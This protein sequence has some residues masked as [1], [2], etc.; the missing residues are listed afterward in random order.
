VDII[1]NI[2]IA[3]SEQ[4]TPVEPAPSPKFTVPTSDLIDMQGTASELFAWQLHGVVHK[5]TQVKTACT[6]NRDALNA[7]VNSTLL[8]PTKFG[9]TFCN[10][11]FFSTLPTP[12]RISQQITEKLT[13]L[14]TTNLWN[15][16]DSDDYRMLI[17]GAWDEGTPTIDNISSQGVMSVGM[18]YQQFFTEMQDRCRSILDEPQP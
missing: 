18:D 7:A 17:C 9:A 4:S 15:F 12:T 10:K 8:D 16:S 6:D 13:H 5:P 1:K 14:F 3:A 11:D 2:C